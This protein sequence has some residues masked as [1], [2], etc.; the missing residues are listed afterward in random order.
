[1][2]V[3]GDL[4]VSIGGFDRGVK[5]GT[6]RYPVRGETSVSLEFCVYLVQRGDEYWGALKVERT[7]M[8]SDVPGRVKLGNIGETKVGKIV[9]VGVTEETKRNI[10]CPRNDDIVRSFRRRNPRNR[11]TRK[12]GLRR[13]EM[14]RT[15]GGIQTGLQGKSYSGRDW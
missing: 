4:T 6:G 1:M 9:E 2:V 12:T 3:E 15:G 11:K 10:H 5:V 7:R 8:M 14:Y 13:R